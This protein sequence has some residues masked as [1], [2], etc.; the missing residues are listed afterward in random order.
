MRNAIA[1]KL[2]YQTVRNAMTDPRFDREH[3][4]R[5]NKRS[6]GSVLLVMVAVIAVVSAAVAGW[7]Y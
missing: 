3:L 6:P 1:P 5:R 2:Q 4:N 7:L